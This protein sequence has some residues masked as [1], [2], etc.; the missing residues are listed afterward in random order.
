VLAALPE[1]TTSAKAAAIGAAAAKGGAVAKSAGLAGFA[2]AVPG[3][4]LMVL[5]FC[6]WF[7][8]D[9][10]TTRSPQMRDFV[11]KCWRFIIGCIAVFMLA[12][13]S[14]ML[15]GW[16][17]AVSRPALFAGLFI[18]LGAAYI[19]IVMTLN[20]WMTRRRRSLRQQEIAGSRPVPLLVPLF[21]YRSKL[22]L[23]GLP[24]V[25][26]RLRGGLDRG[27][28]K[29]WIAV[30][31]SAIGALFAFGAMAIAPISFGGFAFGLLTFGGF[32]IGG[33]SLGGFSLGPWAIGGM[34][35]GWQAFGGCATAWLAAHG[36]VAIAHD[37]AIGGVAL[38]R[39]ANDTPAEAFIRDS[40]FFQN[41]LAAMRYTPWLNLLWMVPPALWWWSRQENKR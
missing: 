23:F 34:A 3:T 16:P 27:P 37:F 21:E 31:D 13:F 11:I 1:M 35:V 40:R 4:I 5:S 24:L 30:G 19:G 33:L 7:R 9:R 8:L 26:I 25:H 39:H 22:A 17:L 14:L 2:S 38:G 10:D 18:G 29:A 36:G 6:F 20:V 32:A 28:V 41:A 15:W 12:M